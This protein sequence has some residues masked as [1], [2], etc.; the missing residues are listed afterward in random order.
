MPALHV[1]DETYIAA[2]ADVVRRRLCD[3]Q[4]WA[5]WFPGISLRCREDRGPA[6][7]RWDVT[8]DVMGTAEVWLERF[9]DGVIVHAYLR[10]DPV[11]ASR[12]LRRDQRRLQG[13]YALSLKARVRTVKDELEHVARAAAGG[14]SRP[15]E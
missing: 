14:A 13:R 10:V 3:E 5:R 9:G 8:G 7:K 12:S 6:G 2:A 4:V 11:R 1:I 15:N